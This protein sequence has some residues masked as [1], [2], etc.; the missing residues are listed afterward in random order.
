[1][2]LSGKPSRKAASSGNLY[3]TVISIAA[4]HD[5]LDHSLESYRRYGVLAAARSF[6]RIRTDARLETVVEVV[7]AI[8]EWFVRVVEDGREERR[9]FELE[10]SRWPFRKGSD[11]ALKVLQL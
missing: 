7:E 2:P 3:G 1:M 5:R 4:W 11:F 9:S 6:V 8:G 10:S